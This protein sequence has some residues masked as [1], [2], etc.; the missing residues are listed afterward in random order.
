M[1]VFPKVLKIKLKEKGREGRILL[2]K[3][4]LDFLLREGREIPPD[5]QFFVREVFGADDRGGFIHLKIWGESELVDF[6]RAR[7]YEFRIDE[8]D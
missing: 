2:V 5:F 1:D 3:D 7:E 4:F 6:V 8:H